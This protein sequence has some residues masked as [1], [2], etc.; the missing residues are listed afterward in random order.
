VSAVRGNKF[1]LKPTHEFQNNMTDYTPSRPGQING[2]GATDALFLKV[3]PGEILTSFNANNVMM[4]L[5]VTRSI[6]SGKS[7]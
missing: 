2:S 1:F 5:H 3:F 6:A 7:A 4:N